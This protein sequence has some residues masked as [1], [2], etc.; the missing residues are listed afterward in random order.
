MSRA[1][2]AA[3][4]LVRATV[5]QLVAGFLERA[6]APVE[7]LLEGA[8][9]SARAIEDPEG[10]VPFVAVTRFVEDAARRQGIDDLGL[11]IG[12]SS[13]LRQLG[14][15]GRLILQSPT[16]HDG[17]ET[18]YRVWP[19]YNSGVR[20]WIVR[21]GDQVDLEHRFLHGDVRDWGQYAAAA[22]MVYL[23]FLS[24]VAGPDWHPTAVGLPGPSQAGVRSIP[25]LANTR[26][27]FWR[28]WITVTFD[29]AVLSRPLPRLPGVEMKNASSGW[30]D[31]TPA[32]G[33]GG[34]V[35]QI[36]TTLLPDGY[37]DIQLVAEAVRMSPR[38]LQRRLHGE[39]LTFARVVARARFAEA[40]RMLGDPARK[41]IDVA[42]DLGYSDHAHFTRAFERW[43]GIPP[44]EFRRRAVEGA[45]PAGS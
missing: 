24:A 37:P 44:R 28:P 1:M 25:L 12:A 3:I 15:F 34:A 11:R 27:E 18:A 41:V 6:G 39:G 33:V 43:T 10:L 42:L 38:T 20:T 4:P 22:L 30:N 21:R 13:T 9:L 40:Q 23:N 7:R 45:D 8:R 17:L 5:A 14:T 36:V 29:A 32:G 31:S 16:L 35:Q 19:G 26:V 2:G